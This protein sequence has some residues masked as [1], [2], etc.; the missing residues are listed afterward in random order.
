MLSCI[1]RLL[2]IDNPCGTSQGCTG[3]YKITDVIGFTWG[4]AAGIAEGNFKEDTGYQI[5]HK[6]RRIAAKTVVS[7]IMAQLYIKGWATNLTR[8]NYNTGTFGTNVIPCSSDKRGIQITSKPPCTYSGMKL[9]SITIQSANTIDID[10]NIQVDTTLITIPISL[11]ARVPLTINNVCGTNGEPIFNRESGNITVWV[12]NSNFQ[13]V[14]VKPNCPTCGGGNENLC[15]SSKGWSMVSGQSIEN[16]LL[17]YGI[18]A[19]VECECNYDRILCDLPNDEFKAQLLKY[20]ASIQFAQL[21]L[22]TERFNYF[23][24]YG[25]DELNQYI[26]LAQSNYSKIIPT[27]IESLRSYLQ[28]NKF[29]GCLKCD[30]STTKSLV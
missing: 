2:S 19:D 1:D 10:V 30:G 14:E 9:R 15:A 11:T 3:I 17:A 7:D 13:P 18:I 26:A 25:R 27:Y 8:G 29:C 5:A 23:T 6:V 16:K 20:Q 24:I 21:G 28:Q 22:Q 12:Q 4:K